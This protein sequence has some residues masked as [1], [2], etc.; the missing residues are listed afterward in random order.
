ML[1][2]L[3]ICELW[4]S[5]KDIV[6]SSVTMAQ[7]KEPVVESEELRSEVWSRTPSD[8]VNLIIEQSDSATLHFWSRTCS[9]FHR[10]SSALLWKEIYIGE[11]DLQTYWEWKRALPP[12]LLVRPENGGIVDFLIRGP[13]HED[14]YQPS[15]SRHEDLTASPRSK[16]RRLFLDVKPDVV[17]LQSNITSQ[18]LEV[19]LGFFAIF[20][21]RL[22]SFQFE[23]SLYQDSMGQI[24]KFEHLRH[25]IL[26]R[27]KPYTRN[28][29]ET[30]HIITRGPHILPWIKL[31]IDFTCLSNM[32]S[33]SY[34]RI[35]RLVTLEARGLAI[36]VR[37]LQH[38][39][40]LS[41]SAHFSVTGTDDTED[42]VESP[43]DVS[44]FIPFLEALCS[45]G[46]EAETRPGNGIPGGFPRMLQTL[47]LDDRYHRQYPSLNRVLESAIEPCRN[48]RLVILN[49]QEHTIARDFLC[50]LG[51]PVQQDGTMADLGVL[52][53]VAGLEFAGSATWKQACSI[54]F[55]NTHDRKVEIRF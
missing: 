33:L 16:I 6:F 8:I 13:A 43:G 46:D 31:T 2:Q 25:L 27:W 51:L 37:H 32:H 20:M 1:Q 26:K 19:T 24:V 23:G 7:A 9:A 36:A 28:P 15:A 34:L 54:R 52:C 38:L 42:F 14:F 17:R 3:R 30:S 18:E 39:T 40:V 35:D 55:R 53:S 48:L 12:P 50:S 49:F 10:V 45:R 11:K 5:T 41:L 22:D 21:T 29:E 47:V 44:P 4:K